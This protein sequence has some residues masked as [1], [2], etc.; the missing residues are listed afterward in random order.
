[1]DD[2]LMDDP[3]LELRELTRRLGPSQAGR[4][5][6]YRA[7][8]RS[9]GLETLEAR[10][11]ATPDAEMLARHEYLTRQRSGGSEQR[12][13]DDAEQLAFRQRQELELLKL[14]I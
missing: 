3:L 5:P 14:Q 2:P 6:A 1:M 8:L 13:G 11:R 12:S 9:G 7:L 10:R 4:S